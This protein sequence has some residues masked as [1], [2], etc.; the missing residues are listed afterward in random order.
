MSKMLRVQLV[1]L[2]VESAV[3]YA[4]PVNSLTYELVSGGPRTLRL[5]VRE[6]VSINY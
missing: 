2:A 1:E 4:W 6:I 3:C 5:G